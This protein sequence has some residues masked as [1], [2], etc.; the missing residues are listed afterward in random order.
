MPGPGGLRH[1]LEPI[2][3]NGLTIKNRVVR[4]AHGTN[5]GRGRMDDDLIAYHAA[6]ARGK[7]LARLRNACD[8]VSARVRGRTQRLSRRH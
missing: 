2:N 6:R 5:I 1:I 4:T 3:I 7:Q 8:R